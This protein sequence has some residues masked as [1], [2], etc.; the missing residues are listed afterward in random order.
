MSNIFDVKK[1]MKKYYFIVAIM[2]LLKTSTNAQWTNILTNNKVYGSCF[3]TSPDTCYVAA[4][5]GSIFRTSNGGAS[6]DSAQTVFNSSWFN[7]VYFP[8]GNIGYACG[9]TAFGMHTSTIAKTIDGGQT[10]DSLLSNGGF[11]E[12]KKIFFVND[13]V[14]YCGGDYF[15]K[16]IDGGLTFTTITLPFNGSINALY[17]INDTVGFVSTNEYINSSKQICRIARTTDGGLNW[18]TNYIDSVNIAFALEIRIND[19]YFTNSMNGFSVGNNGYFLKT[20]DGG[21]NWQVNILFNGS[22]NFIDIAL[23]RVSGIG[24]MASQTY[25]A[26]TGVEGNIYKTTDTGLTWQLNMTDS[27]DGIFSVSMANNDIVYAAQFGNVLK[28]INGGINSISEKNLTHENVAFFPN[29]FNNKISIKIGKIK[30]EKILIQL[31]D[32]TGR[33]VYKSYTLFNEGEL[34]LDLHELT[35]GIYNLVIISSEF[36]TTHKLVKVN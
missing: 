22:P 3:A 16:T 6:W 23:S 14:G 18:T 25:N 32:R 33:I 29:P 5:N 13:S 7:D 28:T 20:N 17:F 26:G 21:L 31:F 35:D 27:L 10:W 8:S 19:I 30:N 12:F 34:L 9:G 36:K 1:K 11:Y 24:Y 2:F 15:V 4:S